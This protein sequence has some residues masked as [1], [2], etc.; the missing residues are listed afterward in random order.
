MEF[1]KNFTTFGKLILVEILDFYD[2]PLLVVVKNRLDHHFLAIMIDQ[3]VTDESWIYIPISQLRL[4][5]VTIGNIPLRD[6]FIN[7][8]SGVAY[9]VRLP[10]DEAM[11][12]QVDDK[13]AVDIPIDLL[14]P[15]GDR[16]ENQQ[17]SEVEDIR[18][19]S[20]KIRRVVLRLRLH[21]PNIK[22]LEAPA[23]ALGRI[24][25]DLQEILNTIGQALKDRATEAGRIPNQILV[26]N[27]MNYSGA[28]QGSFGIELIS[29]Q[30]PNVLGEAE[31]DAAVDEIVEL[32]K[33]GDDPDQLKKKMTE[34]KPRVAK[35]YYDFLGD[36]E[37]YVDKAD[38]EWAAPVSG[39]YNNASISKEIASLAMVV[40]DLGHEEPVEK[41][42]IKGELT[43][44]N[45]R[46]RSFEIISDG[47]VFDGSIPNEQ[48]ETMR[49]IEIGRIY[50]ADIL[51]KTSLRL[52]TGKID[53]SYE[54]IRLR[55]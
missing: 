29:A 2:R 25:I 50:K 31:I 22:A 8:E 10:F 53:I 39:K 46:K 5:Q 43:G 12:A 30:W 20:E 47:E 45:L 14:P 1:H 6:A 35:N 55:P 36:I 44:L 27:M 41:I 9:F 42:T 15:E 16:L 24:L 21:F 49:G 17:S 11:Q 28:Y 33:I 34:L 37:K 3:S 40:I 23:T 19:F 13:L 51:K 4:K 48:I 52:T 26:D 38:I 18:I 7:S 54:L 32:I